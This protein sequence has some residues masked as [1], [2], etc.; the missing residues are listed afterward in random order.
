ME[1]SEQ[2]L[3]FLHMGFMEEFPLPLEIFIMKERWQ[4]DLPL[5]ILCT[6]F[7]QLQCYHDES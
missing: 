7:Q 4:L 3:Y 6:P 2:N 5:I 1:I